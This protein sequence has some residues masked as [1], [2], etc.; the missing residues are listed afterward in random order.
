MVEYILG[1]GGALWDEKELKSTL[2]LPKAKGAVT[3]VRD[4]II[5]EIS[6]RGAL[7]YQEPESLALFVQGKAIFHRN[8]PYAW[9]VA[10]DPKQSKVEGRV[11]FGSLPAFAGGKSVATLGGWQLAISRFSRQPE[12]AWK[13][14]ALMSSAEIQKQIALHMGRAPSRKELY[15]DPEV[16]KK[17]PQFQ[18][19]FETFL[20]AVPRPPTPVYATLSN[21]MQ[22]YFSS[23]IAVPDSDIDELARLASRD[24]NRVLD[25]LRE[26]IA[27]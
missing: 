5:G 19:Q 18:S 14:V 27:P 12:L 22:R 26:R 10:N 23:A 4:Q 11:G 7:A 21:I 17:N 16:L 15:R 24:M 6:H 1:N 13:F 3:F 25:L 9:E 20:Q 8:W 2:H